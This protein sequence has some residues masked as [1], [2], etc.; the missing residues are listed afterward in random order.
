MRV[1]IA[2]ATLSLSSP[3][4]AQSDLTGIWFGGLSDGRGQVALSPEFVDDMI[5]VEVDFRNWA[6]DGYG[7]CIFYGRVNDAGTA[8]LIL[9]T[10]AG[11]T[12]PDCPRNTTLQAQRTSPGTVTATIMGF[13][14]IPANQSFELNEVIRPI[15]PS[16]YATMNQSF[17]ILGATLGQT[18]SAIEANLIAERGY[19]HDFEED[20]TFQT[21]L[22]TATDVTYRK[23]DRSNSLDRIVVSYSA[24]VADA[25]PMQ[26]EAVMVHRAVEFGEGEQLL[27]DTLRGALDRKY[28]PSLEGAND[29]ARIY[30]RQGQNIPRRSD[31][32]IFCE[33]GTRQVVQYQNSRGRGNLQSHCGTILEV[34]IRDDFQTGLVRQYYLTLKG[35]DWLNNDFW[36][37]LAF[38]R[39]EEFS[40]FL[41]AVEG[42]SNEGPEL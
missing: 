2:L 12:R 32:A 10:G 9:N 5:K 6:Q 18:R 8:D 15:V 34:A 25:D 27:G 29:N 22:W 3:A 41:A 13:S 31:T 30:D 35:V 36:D 33:P 4:F 14:N 21:A 1:A 20:Q 7:K 24:E 37:R 16:E 19:L 17:D 28:G 26:A 23:G 38:Q 11:G 39:R 40:K 42:A